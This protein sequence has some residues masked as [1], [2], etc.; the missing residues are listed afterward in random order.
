MLTSRRRTILIVVGLLLVPLYVLQF[1][2]H[3]IAGRSLLQERRSAGQGDARQVAFVVQTVLDQA[4]QV[5]ANVGRT[6]VVK[7]LLSRPL[8]V[9]DYLGSGSLHDEYLQTVTSIVD[10]S[11]FVQSVQI[12][13]S[14]D[15]RVYFSGG[16]IGRP[17]EVERRAIDGVLARRAEPRWLL[18]IPSRVNLETPTP[19]LLVPYRTDGSEGVVMVV[20]SKR[21]VVTAL[22]R[23]FPNKSPFVVYLNGRSFLNQG[24]EASMLEDENRTSDGR[25][26]VNHESFELLQ[27]GAA[28]DGVAVTALV[29]VSD[30]QKRSTLN[31]LAFLG[32]AITYAFLVAFSTVRVIHVFRTPIRKIVGLLEEDASEKGDSPRYEDEILVLQS[33]IVRMMQEAHDGK[34]INRDLIRKNQELQAKSRANRELLTEAVLIHLLKG[35]FEEDDLGEIADVL[36]PHACPFYQAVAF[37]SLNRSVT[38][39]HSQVE[40]MLKASGLSFI[41]VIG[42]DH[43]VRAAVLQWHARI[44]PEFVAKRIRGA[45]ERCGERVYV[46]VGP[47]VATLA[48]LRDSC[49]TAVRLLG[50]RFVFR[51]DTAFYR[52]R[53]RDPSGL[54]EWEGRERTL[55]ALLRS[56][57]Q[58]ALLTF[59][60]ELPSVFRR[61]DS[62]LASCKYFMQRQILVI[63]KSLARDPHASGRVKRRLADAAPEFPRGF[64]TCDAAQMWLAETLAG[65]WQHQGE[66]TSVPVREAM[67]IIEKE[68]WTDLGLDEV[69]RRVGVTASHLAQ[70][71]KREVG[72]TMKEVL[73]TKKLDRAKDLLVS[74]GCSIKEIAGKVGYNSEN[75]F[76][77]MFRKNEGMSPVEYRNEF[78]DVGGL[79]QEIPA[80]TSRGASAC[81]TTALQHA[82]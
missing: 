73:T 12:Y 72:R 55:S 45:I 19:M 34:R 79:V 38:V 62:D 37:R 67:R 50:D 15:D 51:D 74:S 35:Q 22:Q 1:A 44:E 68:Y 28:A 16:G 18:S 3:R 21:E 64:E 4:V 54:P 8:T 7:E 77:K 41:Q 40:H 69:A 76:T 52:A 65:T 43:G 56:R 13:A 32:T 29:P 2:N 30:L 33:R 17:T 49:H 75:H 10:A 58:P 9:A 46:G 59:I 25:V 57:D 82:E 26:R 78:G 31:W 23:L 71:A 48:E 66:P 20:L 11:P 6:A 36:A 5:G 47:L 39:G 81:E 80:D 70:M 60:L 27:Y 42:V 63:E 53:E 14:V 61:M 24:V